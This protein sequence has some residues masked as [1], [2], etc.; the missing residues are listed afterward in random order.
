MFG[1]RNLDPFVDNGPEK[2]GDSLALRSDRFYE[3]KGLLT[4][5]AESKHGLASGSVVPLKISPHYC[6]K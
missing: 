2:A 5:Q 4:S 6:R 3:Q 1:L